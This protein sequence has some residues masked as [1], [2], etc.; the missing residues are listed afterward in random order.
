M[1]IFLN[2][3]DSV[4]DITNQTGFAAIKLTALCQPQLL[5]KLS[6]SI[7]ETQ[8][9]LKDS[10]FNVLMNSHHIAQ[11]NLTDLNLNGNQRMLMNILSWNEL[12]PM[13]NVVDYFRKVNGK[14]SSIDKTKTQF[15][16]PFTQEEEE[17]FNN[18]ITRVETIAHH[19]FKTDVRIMI[20][21]EQTYLQPAINR[22]TMEMM[23]KY[24]KTKSIVF[25][26]YQCYLKVK[27][28]NFLLD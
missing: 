20:D 7:V 17:M 5:L 22:I 28:M 1:E 25:N 19:A 27:V 6:K 23:K 9:L 14:T 21:A 24:N 13:E 16:S 2:C 8:N 12:I 26:T 18:L 11:S 15:S 4:A 3:I 10:T